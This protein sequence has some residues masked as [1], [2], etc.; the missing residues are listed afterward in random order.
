[1]ESYKE[2]HVTWLEN[3]YDLIVAIIVFQLRV[4]GHAAPA[5]PDDTHNIAV[6]LAGR[7]QARP[8]PTGPALGRNQSFRD[9]DSRRTEGTTDGTDSTDKEV[10][11]FI[12]A[13]RAIRGLTVIWLRPKAA[14][15]LSWL[16]PFIF[17]LLIFPF[18]VVS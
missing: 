6:T 5:P 1:M 16:R 14:L 2:R 15:G 13:I 17:L 11:V 18:F 10:F 4:G 8:R 3:F 7:T 12:R 9:G